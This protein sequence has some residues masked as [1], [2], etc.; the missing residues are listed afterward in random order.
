MSL[1]RRLLPVFFCALCA[2][3]ALA[4]SVNLACTGSDNQPTGPVLSFN[5]DTKIATSN[6]GTGASK[7]TYSMTVQMSPAS[8]GTLYQIAT[9]GRTIPSC[10][11]TRPN[12]SGAINITMTNVT[13]S[14]LQL[15]SGDYFLNNLSGPRMQFSLTFASVTVQST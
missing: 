6:G 14:D 5:F 11:L 3:A 15:L 12:G 13:L 2:P 8:Y 9:G 4:A 1:V 7:P 10:V